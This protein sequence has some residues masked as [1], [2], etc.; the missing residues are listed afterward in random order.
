MN[1]RFGKDFTVEKLSAALAAG[2][3]FAWLICLLM[4]LQRHSWILDTH[5]KPIVTDFLEV[6]VAGRTTLHG[7]AASAYDPGLHHA[8][9][10][11]AAGHAFHGFLWWHYPPVVLF[12]AA[13]LA[14][15]P[16]LP[17]FLLWVA[18]TLA[19]FA[20]TVAAIARTRMAALLACA[21]PAV[22][23][24]AI[25]GQNGYFTATLIGCT[26]LNLET[27][28]VLAGV[29]L[30]LLTYKP[31]F[32]ILFP[33][34]LAATGRWRAFATAAAVAAVMVLVPWAV[35]GSETLRA[36]AHFLPR[37]G[38]SLLVHGSAGWNKLQTVYGFARWSG[39]GNLP[40]SL[41]Q[42][43]VAIAVAGALVW[44]WRRNVPFGLKAAALATA[45]MFATPYLYMYDF[46]LLVVAFAFLYRDRAFD[47][48][49]LAGIAFANLCILAFTFGVLI[50]PIGALA[51]ATTGGL[52]VRRA[53]Q[54]LAKPYAGHV[55]LQAA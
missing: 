1:T 27:R 17:A 18:S 24:N 35:F 55:A 32:G 31:Q 52:I 33:L 44:L 4:M 20:V 47:R 54:E 53:A 8:A 48:F 45:S 15:L 26:L 9:Q 41:L 29:F 36:F 5:G 39:W 50:I 7:A 14:L 16:Y 25:A 13:A 6:W 38:D 2:F 37:A 34:V 46:P 22:F 11:A 49:E 3:A 19:C 30:G 42:G 28:P 12:V 23:I 51:A 43:T 10:V 21:M 40:A